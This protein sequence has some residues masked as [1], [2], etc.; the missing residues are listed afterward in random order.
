MG[1]FHTS[2]HP[3][4]TVH[5][6]ITLYP[7]QEQSVD[8]LRANLAHHRR[9]ILCSP[10]GSGKTVVAIHLTKLAVEKGSRVWFVAD[11]QTLV[12][13]TSQRFTEQGVEH[14]VLMGA[15]SRGLWRNVLVCSA[16][17]LESRNFGGAKAT[18]IDEDGLLYEELH[19]GDGLPKPDLI[20]IDECH[21]IRKKI[22]EWVKENNIYTIGLSATPMTKGLGQIYSA[23]VNIASTQQLVKEGY[24]APLRVV[25]AKQEVDVDGLTLSSTGEWVKSEL[26]DR[27][28]QVAGEIVPEW[29][30]QTKKYY[31]GPVKT[32]AFCPTVAD[33]MALA[34]RFQAAGFDFRVIHY[35]QT[36]DEKQHIIDRFKAGD[37]I[38]L[39]SCV[40]LTKGFDA[41]ATR[42]MIDAYPLR[43][44][45]SMHIQKV[46]RVMRTADGKEFG[47]IIDHCIERS[48]RVLTNRGLV[49]ICNVLS[50]DL[51]WDGV[52]WVP[53][54]GAI[55]VG[56]RKVIQYAGLTATPNHRVWTRYGWMAFGDAARRTT[57][58]AKTGF[59]RKAI[60]LSRNRFAVDRKTRTQRRKTYLRSLRMR[61]LQIPFNHRSR[62]PQARTHKGLPIMQPA[63]AAVSEM[64][65]PT[66][67][68]SQIPMHKPERPRM[69]K[70]RRAWH[71]LL[72]GNS[73]KSG[74]MGGG[75]FGDT[76]S[77]D[78]TGS[79]R[80][81][82]KLRTRKFEMGSE[83]DQHSEPTMLVG[84]AGAR[85]PTEISA[86]SIRRFNTAKI[87]GAIDR[88]GNRGTMG[89]AFEE[90]EGEVWD[91][92]GAG[93][94]NRF[95]VEGLLTHNSGNWMGFYD[96]AHAFFEVGVSELDDAKPK[97][98]RSAA[99]REEMV[100]P[101][102]DTIWE[103]GSKVC[104]SCGAERPKKTFGR[105]RMVERSAALGEI[106]VVDGK[107]R[108][109]PYQ[110]DWW[111][112]ICAVACAVPG[113]TAERARKM[114]LAKYRSIFGRWPKGDFRWVD[115]P[116]DPA[117]R[118]YC[119][120]QYQRYK[121]AQR[122]A[123]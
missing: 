63:A 32:I 8:A 21:E 82:R 28:V 62:Q 34:E 79:D 12:N 111:V 88:Q 92:H 75:Q 11:R 14:G 119:W 115:R 49:P 83:T 22:V 53:H 71:H 25:A 36:A 60:R 68:L 16:Q 2:E 17:S 37:H 77:A 43:K 122:K 80:Q 94:R 107:G 35:R 56:T 55:R 85:I 116:P 99:D 27:V 67:V 61:Y 108:K 23:V 114:A 7:F 3:T 121:I 113:I 72:L 65:L 73:S 66:S 29:I 31:G 41:P 39:I 52:E 109:L 45:L 87:D 69:G 26:S 84:A 47:L 20:I 4:R 24:L 58:I 64:G 112:E 78:G 33:S 89:Q 102:C 86:R 40:A 48:Q 9:Q 123:S 81:Q 98:E 118:D 97:A 105:G 103:K 44:S 1:E 10:T 19:D 15:A 6:S 76:R 13:Q 57:P 106:D 74:A 104:V 30:K 91:I 101:S 38:G 46:G 96:P 59:G 100:C 120:R 110:G 18:E 117:V 50:S 70:L 5:M 93:P 42:V 51:L 54:M 90:T 95:T